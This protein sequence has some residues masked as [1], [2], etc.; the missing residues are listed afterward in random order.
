M[1][2]IVKKRNSCLISKNE[3]E[4]IK[5][6]LTTGN[7]KIS[8]NVKRRITNNGYILTTFSSDAI[9]TMCTRRNKISEVCF[10]RFIGFIP[11]MPRCNN[12]H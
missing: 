3:L 2:N 12:V 11:V 4:V 10:I 6:Y 8:T 1:Q 9:P 7:E 5:R